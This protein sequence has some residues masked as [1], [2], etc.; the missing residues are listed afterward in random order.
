M[1]KAD[2]VMNRRRLRGGFT[3]IELMV[4]VTIIAIFAAL[5]VPAMLR[6]GDDRKAFEMAHRT[7]QLLQSARARALSTGSAHL[8]T[9]TSSGFASNANAGQFLVYQGFFN[10]AASPNGTA[11][12]SCTNSTQWTALP[13][14]GVPPYPAGPSNVLVDGLNYM[15]SLD[16]PLRSQIAFNGG[17]AGNSAALCFTPGGRVY[18]AATVAGLSAAGITPLAAPFEIQLRRYPSMTPEG[19]TRSVTI[20]GSDMARVRSY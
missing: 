4:V 18:Y 7:A 2:A 8:V 6:A 17:P 16:S 15:Y 10:L 20:D 5:A 11:T 3:I 14:G 12:S 19:L 9:M 13:T 1:T